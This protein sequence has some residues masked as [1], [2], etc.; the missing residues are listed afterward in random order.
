M[1]RTPNNEGVMVM[2]ASN[3]ARPIIATFLRSCQQDTTTASAGSLGKGSARRKHSGSEGVHV[4]QVLGGHRSQPPRSPNHHCLLMAARSNAARPKI[5]SYA[6]LV[7][8]NLPAALPGRT[9]PLRQQAHRAMIGQIGTRIPN[10]MEWGAG[11]GRSLQPASMIFRSPLPLVGLPPAPGHA[12]SLLC[13]LS[14]AAR[15]PF[16]SSFWD[17]RSAGTVASA[18]P[19]H[20]RDGCICSD[21]SWPGRLHLL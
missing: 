2:R 11:A 15:Q 8:A 12:P 10:Q 1:S 21:Y 13:Q 9:P 14:V 4:A 16:Q 7:T 19:I 18:L 6:R 20:G 17:L 3:A 5:H